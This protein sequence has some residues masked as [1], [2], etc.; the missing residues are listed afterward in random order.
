[1]TVSPKGGIVLISGTGSSCLLINPDGTRYSCGGWGH[2]LGDEGSAFDITK[3]AI[4]AVNDTEQNFNPSKY[5]IKTTKNI[6]LNYFRVI[7]YQS[8]MF[9]KVL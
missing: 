6:I 5:S 1:M 8:E 4:K 2:L 9:T 3:N 7:V